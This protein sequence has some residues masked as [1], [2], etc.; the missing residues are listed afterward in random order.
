[1]ANLPC[2]PVQFADQPHCDRRYGLA[3]VQ[4]ILP[5]F[6]LAVQAQKPPDCP[7]D[8]NDHRYQHQ[9]KWDW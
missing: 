4:R 9:A 5:W 8:Q 7:V 3:H 2:F 1:M 6:W